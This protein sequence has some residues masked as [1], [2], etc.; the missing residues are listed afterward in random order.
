MIRSLIRN[1]DNKVM[2][3]HDEALEIS[4]KCLSGMYDIQLTPRDEFE[5][6]IKRDLPNV[7]INLLMK[8]NMF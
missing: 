3:S 2:V 5:C 1:S 6:F 7:L 8:L 4:K